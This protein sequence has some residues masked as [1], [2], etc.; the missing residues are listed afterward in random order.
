MRNNLKHKSAIMLACF[1]TA[2]VA[3]AANQAEP[4][5]E[6]EEIIAIGD[7]EP[8]PKTDI[9]FETERLISIAGATEDPLQA[10]QALPGV[11]FDSNG[12]PVI[13]GSSP[14]DNAFYIDLVPADK[15]YHVWGNSILNKYVIQNLD[16]YPGAFSSQFGNATGGVVDVTLRDPKNIPLTTTASL[17]LFQAAALLE[18]GV[19]ENQALYL[20]VRRSMIDKLI[21]EDEFTSEEDGVVVTEKPES[22]DYQFKYRWQINEQNTLGITAAGASDGLAGELTEQNNEVLVDPDN[23]GAL[24]TEDRFDSQGL[25][26]AWRSQNGQRG[27]DV[28]ATNTSGQQDISFGAGQFFNSDERKTTLRADYTQTIFSNSDIKLGVVRENSSFDID[29]Q[30]KFVNCS[31]FDSDCATVDVD[32]RNYSNE[33]DVDKNILFLEGKTALSERQS[34]TAGL[35]YSRDNYLDEGRVEPRLRWEAEVS[36]KWNTYLALGQYS[37]LPKL[38]EMA[39]EIGNPNL[40]TVK[41][42]HFVWGVNY[43][44]DQTWNV[45]ADLYYKKISDL[46]ISVN[47]PD[48]PKFGLN[49]SNDAKGVAYGAEFLLNKAR[50]DSNW[51]GW[52]ALSLSKAERTDLYNNETTPFDYD[53]PIKLDLVSNHQLS[54]RWSLGF[55]WTYQT[56]D[57]YTPII[58]VARNRDNPSVLE[59]VYGQRNSFE[60][61]AYHRLDVRATY[62][63]PTSW[64][65]WSVFVDIVNAYGRENV[66]DYLFAPNGTDTLDTP[67]PGFGENVPLQAEVSPGALPSLGIE[68]QF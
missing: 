22:S 68:I 49:Y 20:S 27:L 8:R 15:L 60:S 66:S 67:P 25:N 48:N 35:H 51:D 28:L 19:S 50:G 56:G 57:R 1:L 36:D 4:K 39:D 44:R 34:I 26:W 54:E 24:S 29:A 5:P 13:R 30:V 14:G 31:E 23:L 37:Q 12:E 61:P 46:V 40:T 32:V 41:A 38:Q 7:R 43:Q 42:D 10:I 52:L 9:S 47:D 6:L 11:T 21:S 63:K 18:T 3:Q 62:K 16:L 65:Y 33:L 45:K 59:P 17:S 2:S 53:R 55:R 58:D 64:G